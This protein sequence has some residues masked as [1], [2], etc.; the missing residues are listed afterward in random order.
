MPKTHT[1]TAM[2]AESAF[3]EDD[4]EPFGPA[5]DEA[6]DDAREAGG[7]SEEQPEFEARPS[8]HEEVDLVRMY[9]HHIGR[10]RLLKK[11]DEVALGERMEKGQQALLSALLAL[12][13][14][15]DR[16]VEIGEKVRKGEVPVDTLVLLPEGGAVSADTVQGVLRATAR[17][18]RRR[19]RIEQLRAELPSVRGIRKQAA[20]KQELAQEESRLTHDLDGQPIRPSLLD[21]IAN[22]TREL[23]DRVAALAHLSPAERSAK[24]RVLAATA[25]LPLADLRARLSEIVTA[26]HMIR[27]AKNELMEAN[28]RLVV[29]I[30][31][32]YVNR[33]LSLLDVIQ[34]GNLGLMKAVDKFQFRRGFKFSTY[35][36]WW[37]RQAITRAIADT[38]RT[39]RLPVH[40]IES[41]NQIEKERKAFRTA[42]NIEPTAYELAER[43]GMPV[44]KVRLLMDAQKTPS[45]L[46]VRVG[47]DDALEL[48]ALVEDQSMPSP[49]ESLLDND[50]T[51]EVAQAMAPLT[52]RERHVLSLRFGL[53]RDREYTLEE[54]GQ[55]LA[56]T[57]ERVRQIEV[58]AL[59]KMR[60]VQARRRATAPLTVHG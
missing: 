3:F 16:L 14:T 29:S 8:A 56:V 24:G 22:S 52:D 15:A 30:A 7:A 10:R 21:E 25:G 45:S 28:L 50:R 23:A 47:E 53:G 35:A 2:D 37:I 9:L 32:R 5:G 58:R 43:L 27:E 42:L 34:E 33:G 41:I 13:S 55:Q 48:S 17:V 59:E 31:K 6:E 60:A 36:T 38:G 18:R 11:S 40:V 49:E 51:N 19:A 46:D 1:V 4:Q 57:R 54:I 12:P 44:E 39:I 26:E 20:L